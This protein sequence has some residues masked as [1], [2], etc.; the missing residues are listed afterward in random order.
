MYGSCPALLAEPQRTN[1]LTYSEEFDNAAWQKGNGSVTPNTTTS[2]N[3]N[4]NADSFIEDTA[5]SQH[6][7]T[8]SFS[9]VNGTSYTASYYVKANGRTQIQLEFSFGGKPVYT[10]TGAGSATLGGIIENV[11]NDWYRISW[12]ATA[13]VTASLNSILKLYNAGSTNYT[14]DGTSGIYIWG[15][16]LEAGAYPTTYIPTTTASATRV[17][18]SFSRSN[19]Y[20]NG[21][22]S[23]SGGTWFVELR[24]NVVYTRDSSGGGF[25]INTNVNS[26]TND[27]GFTFRNTGVAS[28]RIGIYK[29]ISSVNTL[30]YTTTT[31]TTKIAIKWNGSTAD[32]FVNGTKQVSATAFTSTLLEFFNSSTVDVPK[33]IQ[34]MALF[35]TPLSDAQCQTLTTL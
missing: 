9:A 30:L 4:T 33:F 12:T 20:T 26:T 1:V 28:S 10:L 6:T 11:G 25:A 24:N 15:A 16:Q 14:G 21:L 27:N 22:I 31:D 29:V 23:A 2:P 32:V 35:P 8:R 18:D 34:Q 7:L 13:S 3:G 19:I 5:T 17:A